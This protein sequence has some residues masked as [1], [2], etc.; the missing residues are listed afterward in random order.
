MEQVGHDSLRASRAGFCGGNVSGSAGAAAA[1]ADGPVPA[2]VP[3]FD[4]DEVLPLKARDTK[5]SPI[6][7]SDGPNHVVSVTAASRVDLITF[8]RM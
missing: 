1:A 6:L 3:L 4:R 7:P 2:R 8:Y 5:D